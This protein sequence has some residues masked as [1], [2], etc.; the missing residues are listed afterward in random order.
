M[1]KSPA[2][3][4]TQSDAL[5]R[6]GNPYAKLQLLDN[7]IETARLLQNPYA[8][9]QMLFDDHTEEV[10]AGASTS[11]MAEVVAESEATQ[12]EF[13]SECRRIF[14]Q[15]IPAVEKGRIRDHHR[16]FID[17]NRSRS[18]KQRSRLLVELR[19]YDISG[20]KGISAQFN[21]ERDKLTADKLARIERDALR[22]QS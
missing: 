14:R 20:I 19:K 4:E 2:K 3:K 7:V 12:R 18:A 21:R 15:Y 11:S 22:E 8:K 1:T 17:R 10:V 16:T 5:R 6:L 9:E 13:E